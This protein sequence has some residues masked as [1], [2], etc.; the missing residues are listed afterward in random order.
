M[1]KSNLIQIISKHYSIIPND[2]CLIKTGVENK[3]YIIKTDKEKYVLRIYN[4]SHSIKGKRFRKEINLEFEFV[5]R[6]KNAGIYVPQV[7]KNKQNIFVTTIN[8]NGNE[9][10]MAIFTYLK[11]LSIKEYSQKSVSEVGQTVDK[12]FKVGKS[13]EDLNIKMKNDLVSRSFK[14]Y[15]NLTKNGIHIPKRILLLWQSINSQKADVLKQNLSLGLI[16][17][18]LK[19]ENLL[20]DNQNNLV[21]VLDFDDYRYSY[22]IEET[23]MALMHSLHSTK[24]N[25]IRSGNYMSFIKQIN[26]PVLISELKLLK[27]FLQVRFLYDLIKYIGLGK[28]MLVKELW[29]DK[30]IQNIILN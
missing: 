7:V 30:R 18:D 20:F 1:K 29:E 12:F 25:I 15:N 5:K 10:F 2:L 11:G 24:K 22:L 27:F 28:N 3:N 21:G 6:S 9:R 17:G 13:F 14:N 4:Q 16:H 23:V 8:I 19:L 26:Q